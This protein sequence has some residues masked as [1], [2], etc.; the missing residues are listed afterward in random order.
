MLTMHSQQLL[1]FLLNP[2]QAYLEGPP[3]KRIALD[4]DSVEEQQS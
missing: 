4:A 3:Q 2:S 1:L